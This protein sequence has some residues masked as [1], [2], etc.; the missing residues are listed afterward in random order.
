[1]QTETPI[2]RHPSQ[3]KGLVLTFAKESFAA[4]YHESL[5]LFNQHYVEISANHD[6]ELKG[7]T[8]RY[9]EL[10]GAG[11]LAVWTVREQGELIGY[12]WFFITKHLHY[13]DSTQAVQD[14]LF[15]RKDKRGMGRKFI[16][17]CDDQMRSMGCQIVHQHVKCA[18]DWSHVLVEQGYKQVEK[19]FSKRLDK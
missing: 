17:Y 10:E 12:G 4:T 5:E 18:H 9:L 3:D 11:A 1:M 13:A 19:I 15:I 14:I 6:I 2:S 16:K 7:D 8:K